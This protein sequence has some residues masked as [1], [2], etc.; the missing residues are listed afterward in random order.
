MKPGYR[1]G[2]YRRRGPSISIFVLIY[3]VVGVLVAA[4]VIGDDNYFSDV[5]SLKELLDAVLAVLL[6][7]LVLLGVS[8]SFGEHAAS[9][10]GSGGGSGK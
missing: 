8:F 3:L 1:L 6:W 5:N 7:P 9:S 2:V 10:G 4:G